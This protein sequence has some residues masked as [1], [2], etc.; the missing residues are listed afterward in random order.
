MKKMTETEYIKWM[1]GIHEEY[2]SEAA[3]Y[4]TEG[5]RQTRLIR[6]VG[7][8]MGAIAAAIAVVIGSFAY[9]E[10]S[11]PQIIGTPLS[12]DQENFLGGTGE[13][14]PVLAGYG[15]NMPAF[16]LHD[17][18]RW[19]C[20]PHGADMLDE[21]RAASVRSICETPGCN[22]TKEDNCPVFQYAG[23]YY[24][25][26]RLLTD[27]ER[28]YLTYKNEVK[29]IDSAGTEADFYTFA[30]DFDGSRIDGD[31]VECVAVYH[32]AES[33]YAFCYE[34]SE[35]E[36]ANPT[37]LRYFAVNLD[38]NERFTFDGGT[39]HFLADGTGTGFYVST[40]SELL[41]QNASDGADRKTVQAEF[42]AYALVTVKD[43]C[44]YYFDADGSGALAYNA[45]NL[46]TGQTETLRTGCNGGYAVAPDGRV[47]LTYMQD[48][49]AF[50]AEGDADWQNVREYFGT[51][52]GEE[53]GS[54]AHLFGN[55]MYPAATAEKIIVS[56]PIGS[57]DKGVSRYVIIDRSTGGSTVYTD[58][59]DTVPDDA[60]E[61]KEP[62]AGDNF[63]GGTGEIRYCADT[64]YGM[65]ARDD[66]YIYQ[67]N[68]G[69]RALLTDDGDMLTG[70]WGS[71]CNIPGC[72]HD[73]P[74]CIL[75]D[76]LGAVWD[77]SSLGKGEG[78]TM[79]FTDGTSLYNAT[80][81][82]LERIEN[83]GSRV[84]L[85]DLTG[86]TVVDAD[87]IDALVR[88][89]ETRLAVCIIDKAANAC[90]YLYDEADGSVKAY[91]FDE[92]SGLP[93]PVMTENSYPNARGTFMHDSVCLS[94]I[95]GD[96]NG[97]YH[98]ISFPLNGDTRVYTDDLP[99][100]VTGSLR[101]W[102]YK[103][104]NFYILTDTALL[105]YDPIN[106]TTHVIEKGGVMTAAFADNDLYYDIQD[107][108]ARDGIFRLT[109]D[110]TPERVT[111]PGGYYLWAAS[112]E[113][114]VCM[115]DFADTGIFGLMRDADGLLEKHYA[116]SFAPDDTGIPDDT[117]AETTTAP[118]E[119]TV[120]AETTTETT[121]AN[122][123]RNFLGGTG[124][125]VPVGTLADC[126]FMDDEFFYF[127]N[128]GLCVKRS[129][130]AGTMEAVN[131]DSLC[132]IPGCEHD[133]DNC[134]LYRYMGFGPYDTFNRIMTDGTEIFHSRNNQVFTVA[135]DGTE[136]S[137]LDLSAYGKTAYAAYFVRLSDA[138]EL[139]YIASSVY[140]DNSARSYALW[141]RA[142]GTLEMLNIPAAF[143]ELF[144]SPDYAPA[145]VTR[146][147]FNDAGTV[148]YYTP[149]LEA[150][151][152]C[153]FDLYNQ[154]VSEIMLP[155]QVQCAEI[156]F[157]TDGLIY[158]A[159][160]DGA[161]YTISE[162]GGAV[163]KQADVSPLHAEN[164]HYQQM[165]RIGRQIIA[166]DRTNNNIVRAD[167]S[168]ANPQVL[169]QGG[170]MT[171]LLAV[172]QNMI[173]YHNKYNAPG[174]VIR[175]EE[176]QSVWTNEAMYT[177]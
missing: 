71:I 15:D 78:V 168:F 48:G 130:L 118:A 52:L 153:A 3:G 144:S 19:Y 129:D 50:V 14:V 4:D 85:F 41:W 39:V 93:V 100:E 82:K 113:M 40:G 51:S 64:R 83:N 80:N 57:G 175:V 125:V 72:A 45:L 63:L 65:F 157:V 36:P 162:N 49:S 148:L 169:V 66:A 170:E 76:Y 84:P 81:G 154:Q 96:R 17:S 120:P 110:E 139:V 7:L 24:P 56:T 59:E 164:E 127:T 37:A 44:I 1:R 43:D 89:D 32:L 27:G 115:N 87:Y 46:T 22:H 47:I 135:N 150:D 171:E 105:R 33:C 68:Q 13:L 58:W 152:I 123:Q 140:A 107:G 117:P 28:L 25:A 134:I 42:S 174:V 151:R 141:D 38:T 176:G 142:A 165:V 34:L 133:N 122:V 94:A 177:G 156:G 102:E 21:N 67:L 61:I 124:T 97:F 101:W 92:N 158:F 74:G 106:Q 98:I 91:N 53:A 132:H 79:P 62:A 55:L 137:V 172:T 69:Y 90:W 159:G 16:Y 111:E 112:P 155:A 70:T 26:K 104:S 77:G 103:N 9:S 99:G 95:A 147:R 138:R 86:S 11:K 160:T 18:S 114:T 131:C 29:L 149:A 108:S 128:Q 173:W 5:H 2:I 23:I 75:Y 163:T 60:V 143:D 73:A 116:V 119:T 20:M 161:W 6:R 54:Y 136:Q 167:L 12:A 88:V 145:I 35:Y 8:G 109:K 166:V 126:Y 30:K 10:R 146:D 31:Q 121:A